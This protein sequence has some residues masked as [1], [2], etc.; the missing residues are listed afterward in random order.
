MSASSYEAKRTAV[1][2]SRARLWV[3]VLDRL[4]QE[5]SAVDP[6]A[7]LSRDYIDR[8][9]IASEQLRIEYRSVSMGEEQPADQST[10]QPAWKTQLEQLKLH[11]DDAA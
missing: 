6:A 2:E 1:R 8:L 11:D 7:P 4:Q 10:K 3:R 9:R 5:E